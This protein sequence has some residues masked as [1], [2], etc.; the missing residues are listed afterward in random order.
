MISMGEII[1]IDDILAPMDTLIL[2]FEG[3]NPFAAVAMARDLLRDMM[4]IQ[5]KDILETDI[6]WDTS[7]KI[8]NFYGKWM[9]KR[10]EDRWTRT[11]IRLIMQG[12]Q[13]S[14]DKTGWVEVRFKGWIETKYQ[15]SNFIQRTFW[16]FFNYT[17]YHRQRQLYLEYAKDNIYDIR[18]KLKSVFGLGEE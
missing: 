2:K 12:E 4:K 3:K 14:Q 15:Y 8:P 11:N 13:N 18:D 17:F 5:T 6:R 16:W 10:A 1:I 9:G 7:G